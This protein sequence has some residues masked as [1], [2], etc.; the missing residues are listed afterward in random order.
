MPPGLLLDLL[1]EHLISSPDRCQVVRLTSVVQTSTALAQYSQSP[2]SNATMEV[3]MRN[4]PI[5][6]TDQGLSNH[7]S[8]II[9]ALHIQDW[10][11]QKPRKRNFGTVTFLHCQDGHK[12][13]QRHGQEPKPLLMPGAK[14]QFKARLKIL[15]NWVYC[16]P[17]NK[18]VDQFQLKHMLRA[19]EERR[20]A[21]E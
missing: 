14:Q 1:L 9:K 2:R 3:F 16:N 17:S 20:A 21:S 4:L 19:A 7:L 13:L 18:A 12:F 6:L 15:N 5:D 10:T 11:C 8:P